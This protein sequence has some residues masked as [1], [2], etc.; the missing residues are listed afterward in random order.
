MLLCTHV[1]TCTHT[2]ARTISFSSFSAFKMETENATDFST[3]PDHCQHGN[4]QMTSC[5]EVFKEKSI[6]FC[7][8]QKQYLIWYKNK[9]PT[10]R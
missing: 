9:I 6:N 8:K 3:F 10:T 5:L 7:P 1:S 4:S 2:C